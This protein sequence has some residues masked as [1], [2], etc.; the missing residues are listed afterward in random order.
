MVAEG[1]VLRRVEHLEQRRRR[2]A[3][4][5]GADLVDLVEQHDR[6]HR[7]GLLDGPHD[8]AGQRADVRA[9]VA[10]DLGLVADAAERDA[11]ELAAHGAGHRLAERGLADAGR[12]GQQ[13]HR[14]GAPAADHLQ[15]AL[16]AAG[17]DGEVLD[18][19]LLD[20]VEAVVVGVQ[21]LAG[22]GDVVAVVGRARPRQLEHGVEPGADPGG[23]GVLL[24]GPLELVDLPE[25]RLAHVVGHLGGLH[26][27]AVVVGALG[28]AL[29]ELLADRRELL[30]EQEL[31]LGLLHP[32]ADVLA[33]LVGDLGL[34]EVV[35]GPGDDR[36]EPLLDVR[37]LQQ[38]A[39]LLVGEVRRVAGRVR[40]RA[41]VAHL[42][43]RCR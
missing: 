23:L 38:L 11:D 4:V 14:A 41:G 33:D 13:D 16:G 27:A 39:L 19:P 43:D 34:G 30:A 42:V 31:A 2:V 18:D 3:A 5:V 22:A 8:A 29:A 6:V 21:H 37:G 20:L 25:Q 40:D 26:P 1:V 7:A 9:P 15:A 28:L 36:L 12:A 35:A 17:A 24:A 10:T 32:L